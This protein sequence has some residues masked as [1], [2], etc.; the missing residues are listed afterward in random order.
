MNCRPSAY[1]P[2]KGDFTM[3]HIFHIFLAFAAITCVSACEIP[4]TEQLECVCKC[5]TEC[6]WPQA[7]QV[8][9]KANDPTRDLKIQHEKKRR[10][11][12]VR[13][14][15]LAQDETS[16]GSNDPKPGLT[17]A[18][19]VT[20]EP[21]SGRSATLSD[22]QRKAMERTFTQFLAEAKTRNIEGMKKWTTQRLS[23]S[24]T[25]SLPRYEDRLFN[26]L[27][28]SISALPSGLE[29]GEARNV[30]GGN[31]EVLM[32]FGNGHERRPVFF[33][34]NG[35]WRLNRL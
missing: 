15:K 6:T 3:K 30:S 13:A 10:A 29:L 12:A 22:L 8:A 1:A 33:E 9:G 16:K 25:Q 17:N 32:R 5:E 26:S 27:R 20:S 18:G 14:K 24:L 19:V 2:L 21:G 34:E 7:A 28:E 35:L 31:F 23:T 4:R 11:K